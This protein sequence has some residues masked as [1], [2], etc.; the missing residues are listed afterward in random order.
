MSPDVG[1]TAVPFWCAFQFGAAKASA[2]T[3]ETAQFRFG[4]SPALARSVNGVGAL[5]SATDLAAFSPAAATPGIRQAETAALLSWLGEL[6][7]A[8]PAEIA[9]DGELT[10]PEDLS[11]P[12]DP[13]AFLAGPV[14]VPSPVPPEW[15]ADALIRSMLAAGAVRAVGTDRAAIADAGQALPAQPTPE[16]SEGSRIAAP[17]PPALLAS[18]APPESVPPTLVAPMGASKPVPEFRRAAELE[19][20]SGG[21]GLQVQP[22]A[23]QLVREPLAF[24]LHLTP[25]EESPE[26]AW[27]VAAPGA[28][29]AEPT[30]AAPAVALRPV[31]AG[32]RVM[33][34][35]AGLAAESAAEPEPLGRFAGSMK[36]EDP[37]GQRDSRHPRNMQEPVQSPPAEP[38]QTQAPSGFQAPLAAPAPEPAS[39]AGLAPEPAPCPAAPRLPEPAA[40]SEPTPAPR[41]AAVDIGLRITRPDAASIE[42]RV[43]ERAGHVQVD[44]RTSDHILKQ[45]LRADLGALTES[46]AGAGYRAEAVAAEGFAGAAALEPGPQRTLQQPPAE[47]GCFDDHPGRQQQFQ[48]QHEHQQQQH[49][50]RRPPLAEWLEVL[51]RVA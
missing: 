42:V 8:L 12:E 28:P 37:G 10:Q 30:P 1:R 26:P 17:A 4:P 38:A 47:P 3:F 16:P 35:A 51:E 36:E 15:I 20:D 40:A 32:G 18:A 34:P 33:A 41:P 6:L 44:V 9:Q 29:E 25:S 13:Q 21:R 46:L 19:L 27:P 23:A 50:Q 5:N 31:A 48:Q 14:A 49:Q 24:Q 39:R 43:V 2:K 11:Q 45:A 22:I 7:Q